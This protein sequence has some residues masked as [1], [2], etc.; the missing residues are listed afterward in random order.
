MTKL[1]LLSEQQMEGVRRVAEMAMT[2]PIT[3]MRRTGDVGLDL[4]DDPYGGSV[5]FSDV[6][7][8]IGCLG[9]LHSTPTPVAVMDA[10]ALITVNTY[11]LFVPHD[12]DIRPG[13]H[14]VVNADT[15]VVSDTTAD[16]T[17]P[18]LL[19]CTLRLRE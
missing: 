3:I 19:S 14:V 13:D 11:R 8:H 2:T 4:S 7:P 1:K 5:S 16:E 9:W 18:A 6:T 10:G 12:I 17:W 15:Y